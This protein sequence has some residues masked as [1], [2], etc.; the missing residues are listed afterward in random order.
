MLSY[1]SFLKERDDN[2]EAPSLKVGDWV[3]SYDH[4]NPNE[5]DYII[6]KISSEA[7]NHYHIDVDSAYKKGLQVYKNTPGKVR[8]PKGPHPIT[9]KYTVIKTNAPDIKP[10]DYDDND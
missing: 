8:A 3:K 9:G 1:S 2:P 10:E 5:T 7:A 4:A 6:G